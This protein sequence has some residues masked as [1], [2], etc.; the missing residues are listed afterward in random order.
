[1]FYLFI[2][3]FLFS[4]LPN[5]NSCIHLYENAKYEEALYAC[6]LELP[7]QTGKEKVDSFFKLLDITHELDKREQHK[8]Y[9]NLIKSHELFT[10]SLEYQWKWQRWKGKENFYSKNL[11]KAEESFYE[12][13]SLATIAKNNLWISESYNDLGVIA[14]INSDSKTALQYFN[15]SLNLRLQINDSYLIG[16]GYSNIGSVY[17]KLEEYEHAIK[18]FML[19]IDFYQKRNSNKINNEKV[20]NKINHT[21]EYL[22]K[23]NLILNNNVAAEEMAEMLLK[24]LPS[25]LTM[26]EK[27]RSRINFVDLYINTGKYELAEYFLKKAV[28]LN[29]GSKSLFEH[30]IK[31]LYTKL[32]QKQNHADMAIQQA[33]EG[34]N[35]THKGDYINLANFQHILSELYEAI[36]SKESIKYL[37]LYQKNR[38]LH[39][40][41]KFNIDI[42]TVQHQIEKNQIEYE[43]NIEKLNN[44][45]NTLKIK[46]LNHKIL[47]MVILL[48][49]LITGIV[50]IY[51]AKKREKK[52][53]LE[54]ILFHKQQLMVLDDDLLNKTQIENNS[55]GNNKD[56]FC[57]HLVSTMNEAVNIWEQHTQT[58]RVELADQSGIWTISNDDGT[59]R[60][61]SLDK[62]LSL[63]KI[64]KNPRW[65]N[66]VR[67]CHFILSD[68]DL[69]KDGRE[70]LENKLAK[71]LKLFE[72]IQPIINPT[73]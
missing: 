15:K 9:L 18:Y 48:L 53:F 1:M 20:F 7:S 59:L 13:L 73:A 22:I 43:L 55:Q 14:N 63:D 31:Y 26:R 38:E 6:E 5:T 4:T 54:K 29:D 40:E 28:F 68:S 2:S 45:A 62:Y 72:N 35:I 46:S 67:T 11:T 25:T 69:N 10:K 21:Y 52:Y 27:V 65:R 44:I 47:A 8:N 70:I 60:T 49:F 24:Q 17:L 23:V 19:A 51:L 57:K 33:I 3:T 61:R 56:V 39:L 50:I 42:K 64:P 30:E 41:N 66:V 58:N 71:V 37:K 16:M 36:N 34:I 12:A 32:Y